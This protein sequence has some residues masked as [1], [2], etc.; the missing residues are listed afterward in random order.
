MN[1]ALGC[2]NHWGQVTVLLIPLNNAATP[3]TK[4]SQAYA[5]AL[6]LHQNRISID[7][8]MAENSSAAGGLGSA[9]RSG[10]GRKLHLL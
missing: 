2:Y 6:F 1:P 8:L 5:L 3:K 7:W 10:G 4:K 9:G